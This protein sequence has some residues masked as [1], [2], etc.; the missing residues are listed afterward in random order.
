MAGHI[1]PR[2]ESQAEVL[3]PHPAKCRTHGRMLTLPRLKAGDS[4][5]CGAAYATS[6]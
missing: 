3:I 5:F 1:V 2:C 6:P 4:Q